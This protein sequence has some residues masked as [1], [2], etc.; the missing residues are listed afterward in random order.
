MMRWWLMLTIRCEERY[1]AELQRNG[2]NDED[3]RPYRY[4]CQRL[5][6]RLAL[7]R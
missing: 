4:E 7:C 5:R 6:V 1:I 3:T 2:W